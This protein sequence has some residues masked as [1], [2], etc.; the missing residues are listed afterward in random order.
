MSANENNQNNII[1]D[2]TMK[3]QFI[4]NYFT[5][6]SENRFFDIKITNII[7]PISL[8]EDYNSKANMENNINK[9][10]ITDFST[11]YQTYSPNKPS[12]SL[13]NENIP[14]LYDRIN[15]MYENNSNN[16][17]HF[18]L[19]KKPKLSLKDSRTKIKQLREKL[20]P[21]SDE[22]K[23]RKQEELLPVPLEKMNDEKYKILKMKNLKKHSL[24]NYKSC[25]KY[26]EYYKPFEDSLNLKSKFCL[27]K[28]KKMYIL[29]LKL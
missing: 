4:P 12:F 22:E 13:K 2:N 16:N 26:D 1:K 28:K 9:I 8:S 24:P 17:G 11:N 5:F 29:I 6:S 18:C 27:L 3:K 7:N 25:Q 10:K 20:Y 19:A 23:I 14:I 21:L 15:N